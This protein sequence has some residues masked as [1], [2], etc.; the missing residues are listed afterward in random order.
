MYVL[1]G[2]LKKQTGTSDHDFELMT[3]FKNTVFNSI[4]NEF[5][6]FAKNLQEQ[7]GA[8]NPSSEN[9]VAP[10]PRPIQLLPYQTLGKS[11]NM[12]NSRTTSSR[13]IK[14]ARSPRRYNRMSTSN[15]LRSQDDPVQTALER[16][17]RA[18]DISQP[19]SS[20]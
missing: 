8:P 5:A 9:L 10:D 20:H 11:T 19:L 6:Q 2:I 16:R 3:E 7:Y 1:Q 14:T 17:N 13:D 4:D 18:F 15:S 12:N